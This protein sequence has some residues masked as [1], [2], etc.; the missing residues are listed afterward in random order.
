MHREPPCSSEIMKQKEVT[1]RN[2]RIQRCDIFISSQQG[3][4]TLSGKKKLWKCM[5]PAHDENVSGSP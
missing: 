1:A 3:M 2:F 5:H 4:A